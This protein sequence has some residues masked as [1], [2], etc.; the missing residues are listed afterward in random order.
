MKATVSIYHGPLQITDPV[1]VQKEEAVEV[2]YRKLKNNFKEG[3]YYDDKTFW[4]SIITEDYEQRYK[5]VGRL[6]VK[7]IGFSLPIQ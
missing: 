3:P 5:I 7:G 1:T 2:A 4:A 6:I